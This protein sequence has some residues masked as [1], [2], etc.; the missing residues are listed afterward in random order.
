MNRKKNLDS[1]VSLIQK[2]LLYFF[3]FSQVIIQQ[4]QPYDV[5]I[6]VIVMFVV[7]EMSPI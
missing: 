3:T 1:L 2:H 7:G 6:I 4:R 5:V